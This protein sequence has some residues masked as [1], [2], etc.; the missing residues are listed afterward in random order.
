MSSKQGWI[1]LKVLIFHKGRALLDFIIYFSV[2]HNT[3]C[4]G[5][6]FVDLI[7]REFITEDPSYIGVMRQPH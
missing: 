4:L 2:N 7:R 3:S 1:L 6:A 5:Y